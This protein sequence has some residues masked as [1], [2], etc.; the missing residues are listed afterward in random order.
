MTSSM[1]LV[2][3]RPV[4]SHLWTRCLIFICIIVPILVY[5]M[6]ADTV[7]HPTQV[8]TSKTML[9]AVPQVQLPDAINRLFDR[10]P[11]SA[12]AEVEEMIEEYPVMMFSMTSCKW[13][14]KAKEVLAR[15]RITYAYLELDED[16]QGAAFSR[17]LEHMTEQTTV[18]NIFVNGQHLGGYM[19]LLNAARSGQLKRMLRADSER[20]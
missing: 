9:W 19:E 14:T 6:A 3:G 8:Q 5:F 20:R 4:R 13:C 18:P 10:W 7:P 15:Q 1:A 16:P 2:P 12:R 17:A 11:S